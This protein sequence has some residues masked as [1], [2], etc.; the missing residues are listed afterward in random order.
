[1]RVDID[2]RDLHPMS[3]GRHMTTM[4]RQI[5]MRTQNEKEKRDGESVIR[6]SETT[7]PKALGR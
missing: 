4:T 1:M 6:L 2:M 5:R 7:F 3:R